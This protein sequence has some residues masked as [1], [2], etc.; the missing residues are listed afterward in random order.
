MTLEQRINMLMVGVLQGKDHLEKLYGSLEEN[1]EAM[2]TDSM[3]FMFGH[4]TGMMEI[5]RVLLEGFEEE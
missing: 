5:I 3:E 2:D 4:L 1:L